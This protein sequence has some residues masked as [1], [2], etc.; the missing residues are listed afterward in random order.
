MTTVLALQACDD[1]VTVRCGGV[2]AT[3][4]VHTPGAGDGGT[5]LDAH[6]PSD[7]A[8]DGGFDAS[9]DASHDGGAGG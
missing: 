5:P 8:I 9:A 7:A 1:T 3:F 2:A 6:P 4:H